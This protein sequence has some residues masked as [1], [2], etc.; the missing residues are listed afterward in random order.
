MNHLSG[1]HQKETSMSN[2]N[3]FRIGGISAFLGLGFTLADLV[4]T[5]TTSPDNV[6][7][8]SK[9]MNSAAALTIIP[10]VLALYQL[11]RIKAPTFSMV[12]VIEGISAVV[13]F[14]ICMLI[15]N[16]QPLVLYNFAFM[17]VYYLP[18]MLFGLLAY[19]QPQSGM[20]R[21]LNV[22]GIVTGVVAITRY[23]VLTMGG[24]DW[25]NLPATL[26]PVAFI[27]YLTA[28]GLALVW[29]VWTGILLLRHKE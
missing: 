22:I 15:L 4:I 27:L 29:L 24:G 5:G 12:A 23:V 20:P 25:M 9:L 19:Q 26:A 6:P 28:T 11:F 1:F 7:L 2:N 17:A 16:L 21:A 18:P 10:L 8:F 14:V 3:I 13:L